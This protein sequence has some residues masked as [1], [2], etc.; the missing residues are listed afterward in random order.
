LT[1]ET[2]PIATMANGSELALHLHTFE[3]TGPG[4]TLGLRAGVHGDEAVG[5]EIL[6]RFAERLRSRSFRGRILML[7]VANPLALQNR[8]RHTPDDT[9]RRLTGQINEAIDAH[10]IQRVDAVVDFHAGGY[11]PTVDY[12]YITNAEDLSRA[13][14]SPLLYRPTLD[15]E[16]TGG[17]DNPRR[18]VMPQHPVPWVTAELGG[19]DVDQAP[20]VAR[21]VAGIQNVMHALGMCDAATAPGS[22]AGIPG[23]GPRPRQTVVHEIRTLRPRNGGLL[24]TEAPGLGQPVGGGAVLGRVLNPY[25]FEELEV[26]R[27]PLDRGVMILSHQTV[28]VVRPAD[29]GYMI[30]D[31]SDAE[32]EEGD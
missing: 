13:F 25:T 23:S 22:P 32:V 6:W 3:G 5:V 16:G 11:Y 2:V 17:W 10:F 31:L 20:Y 12:V 30:G 28:D 27:C 7:P 21:G 18:G 19:G 15:R 24:V 29:Y 8:S 9:D 4:P 14:G 1:R 26:F